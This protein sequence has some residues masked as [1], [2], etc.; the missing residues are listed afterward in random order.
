M[1][2]LGLRK[3]SHGKDELFC[4]N[5]HYKFSEQHHQ[6]KQYTIKFYCMF[7]SDLK[8][9]IREVI[10]IFS[11]SGTLVVDWVNCVYFGGILMSQQK[12]RIICIPVYMSLKGFKDLKFKG[13][14]LFILKP[15]IH[16]LF[17]AASSKQGLY[18][19]LNEVFLWWAMFGIC[20]M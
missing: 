1:S 4:C 11:H 18:F 2:P 13:A 6:S 8:T 7:F 19:P 3:E 17:H 16:T 10:T 12:I 15:K 14:Y 5:P 20:F 9:A